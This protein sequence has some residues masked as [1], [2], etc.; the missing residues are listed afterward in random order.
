MSE[1]LAQLQRRVDSASASLTREVGLAEV[2]VNALGKVATN[3]WTS[4]VKNYAVP[5]TGP[6]ALSL[7]TGVR[8]LYQSANAITLF[9]ASITMTR[10]NCA[11][12]PYISLFEQSSGIRMVD[13]SAM[14]LDN[15]PVS[16]D[17][18]TTRLSV[19]ATYAFKLPPGRYDAILYAYTTN[20]ASISPTANTTMTVHSATLTVKDI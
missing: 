7:Y 17:G 14:F 13:Q 19:S 6:D 9:T 1:S 15:R 16:Q 10:L 5:A 4:S 11:V 12:M 8:V 2:G 20:N 3:A 18:T